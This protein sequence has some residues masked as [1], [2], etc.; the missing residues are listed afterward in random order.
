THPSAGSQKTTTQRSGSGGQSSGSPIHVP[1]LHLAALSVQTLSLTQLS[2]SWAARLL[3]CGG[4]VLWSHV[5]LVQALLS[6]QSP[7][8]RQ[9]LGMMVCVQ[10]WSAAH[11]SSVHGMP[12]SHIGSVDGVLPAVTVSQ[13]P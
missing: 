7:S 3:Q 1:P 8:T 12:S 13:Q 5:S 2:P 10:V 6:S 9:H 4:V 11:W